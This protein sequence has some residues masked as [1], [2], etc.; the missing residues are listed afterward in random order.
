MFTFDP[1]AYG[2]AFTDL[3]AGRRLAPLG[4]GSPDRAAERALAALML[5]NVFAHGTLRDRE[6]GAACLA[7]LW[8]AY[9]FLAESHT[10][11]QGIGTPTGSYWHGLMHRREPDFGNTAY[12]FRRMGHHPIFGPLREEAAALAAGAV[13]PEAA[14]LGKQLLWDAFRFADLCEACLAGRSAC[15]ALCRRVQH[16]EW[17]LLFDYSYRQAVTARRSG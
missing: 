16:C 4:P 13:E 14:F 6:M 10:L 3:L 1:T 9:D 5:D 12:W 11:S 2:P 17:E 8:L 15:E 7:G